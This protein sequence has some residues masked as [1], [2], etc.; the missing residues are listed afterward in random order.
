VRAYLATKNPGKVREI[1]RLFAGS[2]LEVESFE[3]YGDVEETEESYEG[4]ALRK[5]RVL[6]AQ[7]AQ[8]G[9]A[10]AALADDSGLEVD[11][12]GGR[13]GVRSARYAGLEASWRARRAMLLDEMR[14]IEGDARTARFVCVMALVDAGGRT[15][16]VRG[17][18]AGALAEREAGEGGFGYDSIFYYP[19]RH[20]TFAQMS[21]AE[22]NAISHRRRAADAVLIALKRG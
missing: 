20:R 6:A 10:A 14:G 2:A 3:E 17:T 1:R 21:E 13:P 5:A 4:N 19:P 8:R 16:V 9:I 12:L 11:A 15:I 22:K 18:V 7:L